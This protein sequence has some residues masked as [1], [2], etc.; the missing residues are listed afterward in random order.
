MKK[1]IVFFM[2]FVVMG[3]YS[4]SHAFIELTKDRMN[5]YTSAKLGY[6][7]SLFFD[8]K[9][10]ISGNKHDRYLSSFAMAIALGVEYKMTRDFSLR[11]EL[12]Y[13]YRTEGKNRMNDFYVS[14]EDIGFGTL[15]VS[16]EA[17]TVLSQIYLDWYIKPQFALY[18]N[19]GFGISFLK[20]GIETPVAGH[21]N[22]ASD[23]AW[24][25][26]LGLLYWITHSLTIDTNVR[27]IGYSTTSVGVGVGRHPFSAIAVPPFG[28]VDILVGIRYNF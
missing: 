24:S 3:Q 27:Y 2:F 15:S 18:T 13:A 7:N 20:F 22:F 8:V 26:G 23:F 12:E 16:S 4:S 28:G 9:D 14:I 19:V 17:Q 5:F 21:T 25:T 11:L 10:N 1:V 6:S